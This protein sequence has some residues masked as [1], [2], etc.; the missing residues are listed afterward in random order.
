M[1]SNNVNEPAAVL[2]ISSNY[3]SSYGNRTQFVRNEAS[4]NNSNVFNKVTSP[5]TNV[6]F[7][8]ANQTTTK[9]N[10]QPVS[11]NTSVPTVPA[12]KH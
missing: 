5:T 10:Y 3:P 1:N 8:G 4:A 12:E 7:M 2:P 11:F 6:N 9:I